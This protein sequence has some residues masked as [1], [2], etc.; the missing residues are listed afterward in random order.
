MTNMNN[1]HPHQTQSPFINRSLSHTQS[2]SH[3]QSASIGH[4]LP[5]FNNQTYLN[6][7][8]I[9]KRLHSGQI[10]QK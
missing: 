10:Q 2:P 6:G 4:I 9:S 1:H 7:N 5:N 3:T 8:N